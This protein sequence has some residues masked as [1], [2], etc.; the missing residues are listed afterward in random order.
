MFP[1]SFTQRAPVGRAWSPL[2]KG[3][4]GPQHC[5]GLSFM[6]PDMLSKVCM[7]DVENGESTPYPPTASENLLARGK[8]DFVQRVIDAENRGGEAPQPRRPLSI[9]L[10][11]LSALPGCA[12][13][14]DGR[15][16]PRQPRRE[17]QHR[18]RLG[19]GRGLGCIQRQ[20]VDG[21]V[22]G[23][24]CRGEGS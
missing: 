22:S 16:D 7:R 17:Q 10:A 8:C 19:D 24:P 9:K 15:A 3:F 2:M 20:V 14:A 12:T 13:P 4:N 18:G 23:S 6:A 1:A 5:A 11:L 21:E